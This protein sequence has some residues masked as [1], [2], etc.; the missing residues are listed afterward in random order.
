MISA[1]RSAS[2]G[3]SWGGFGEDGAGG[4]DTEAIAAA[5]TGGGVVGASDEALGSIVAIGATGG[6]AGV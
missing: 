1:G 6:G 5:A 4:G 3:G 2:I